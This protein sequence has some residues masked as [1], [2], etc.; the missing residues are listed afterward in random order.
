MTLQAGGALPSSTL[1]LVLHSSPETLVV[2]GIIA[3]FSL[4]GW[5]IIGV[6]WRQFRKV[7]RQA[8][9]FFRELERASTLR[10]AYNAVMRLPSSP[11]S[12]LFREGMHFLGELRP[13]A[14]TTDATA[15]AL[16]VTQ[17]EALKMIL[18]K[19]IASE[20]DHLARYVPT[21]ATIGSVGPLLGLLGTVI[22]V[23]DAFIGIAAKGSGN[24]GAV[25][26]GV[27]E[28]LITTVGGLAAAIPAV[29]GYN[30]FVNRV[31]GVTSE[32]DG[33]G[34]ELIGTMAREG[35]I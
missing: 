16:T 6:K 29:I 27:S 1:D 31:R 2:L 18:A 8:D 4:V 3:V 22:G 21:L 34:N 20:R 5:F 10:E 14:L 30:L 9:Q 35:L 17:L 26:P 28:A 32:L 33:F 19:E 15:H 24:L 12:R 13:A 11:Y 23:M 7:R 25:A